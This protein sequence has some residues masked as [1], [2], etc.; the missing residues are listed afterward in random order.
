MPLLMVRPWKHPKTGVYWFRRGVPAD[1]QPRVGKREELRT[2]KTKDPVEARRLFAEVL[3]EVE[4]RWANLRRPP[5]R[6]YPEEIAALA[7]HAALLFRPA[8]LRDLDRAG[9]LAGAD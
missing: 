8:M 6:L 4:E 1:L 3:L 7:P 2:L 5:R 9:C